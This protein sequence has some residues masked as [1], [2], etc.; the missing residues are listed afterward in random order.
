MGWGQPGLARKAH[1]FK[2]DSITSVCSNWMYSGNTNFKM[3]V[4]LNGQCKAC[5]KR[6]TA[7][8]IEQWNSSKL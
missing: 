2:D 8:E 3:N 1:F 6:M 7:K 5:E 4:F